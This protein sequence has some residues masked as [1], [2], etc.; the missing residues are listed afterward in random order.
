MSTR[1]ICDGCRSHLSMPEMVGIRGEWR[2]PNGAIT[3][4]DLFWVVQG[5]HLCNHCTAVALQAVRDANPDQHFLG[6][7]R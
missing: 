4:R 2:N 1:D 6:G 7:K 3:T 5:I